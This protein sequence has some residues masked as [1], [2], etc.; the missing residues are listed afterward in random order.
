MDEIKQILAVHNVNKNYWARLT[1]SIHERGLEFY[2]NVLNSHKR[3]G[4][5]FTREKYIRV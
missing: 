3:G 5:R 2:R 1:Q 4:C